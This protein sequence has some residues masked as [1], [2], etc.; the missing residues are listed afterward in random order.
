MAT[1]AI[2]DIQGCLDPLKQLLEQIQFDP[3]RDQLWFTGDLVNRGPQSLETLRFVKDLGSNAITVL[4][5]HDL[6]LLAVSENLSTYRSKNDTLDDILCAEDRD[7]LLTWL[8]HQPLL[9][10]DANLNMTMIHAGIA[11]QW[12]L[13]TAIKLAKEVEHVLQAE[14]YRDFLTHMY[15]DLPDSWHDE[16]QGHDRIRCI[17]N[18]FTRLRYCT[19]DGKYALSP[20]GAIGTQPSG[21]YPWFQLKQ[22]RTQQDTIIFGH[23]STLGLYT[24]D[25]V[26]SLDTGCLWG[27]KLSAIKLEDR[28]LFQLDCQPSLQP[29]SG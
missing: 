27:G 13:T 21:T 9:H 8:R 28:S 26:I 14:N 1:Y 17:V 3:A 20:K 10:H 4:G 2:G 29:H 23:W 6:H 5:N 22:R 16:L 18:S 15:G 25:N 24:D 19:A 7:E 12:N 11:P